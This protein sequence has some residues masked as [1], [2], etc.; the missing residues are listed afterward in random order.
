M[1]AGYPLKALLGQR[2][3]IDTSLATGHLQRSV[4]MLSP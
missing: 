1:N 4:G 2:S 3:M